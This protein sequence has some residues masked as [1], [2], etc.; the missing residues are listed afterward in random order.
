M[1]KKVVVEYGKKDIELSRVY[2]FGTV[3]NIGTDKEPKEVTVITANELNGK[4]EE[5]IAKNSDGKLEGFVTISIATGLTYEEA[6]L[7]ASKDS[8]KTIG[9]LKDF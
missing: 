6:L 8:L 2:P 5:I 1:S 3:K 7:M 4:D 9:V